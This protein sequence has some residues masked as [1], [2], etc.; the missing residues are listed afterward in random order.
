MR[1]RRGGGEGGFESRNLVKKKK[2]YS[3][4]PAICREKRSRPANERLVNTRAK[5]ER[6]PHGAFL[7][8][9]PLGHARARNKGDSH[10]PITGCLPDADF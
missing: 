7:P 1:R 2:E 5:H 10:G 4:A 3:R 8:A 6:P 9:A